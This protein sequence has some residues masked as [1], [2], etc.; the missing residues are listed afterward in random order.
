M[1]IVTKGSIGA[2]VAAVLISAAMVPVMASTTPKSAENVKAGVD[3]WSRGEYKKAVEA[4]RPAAIAGDPDAQFNLGQAYKLGRGVP[5]D[6]ALAEEWYRK[7]ALQDHFQ[8][9]DAYGLTLFQNNKRAEAVPWL[10][11]SAKRGEP[12]AQLVLG[13]MLFNGDSIT[14]DWVR[15]YALLSR[16][17]AA[18]LPQ[19]AKTLAQMDQYIPADTRQQ[20][21]AL[22]R[23]YEAMAERPADLPEVA[24]AGSTGVR[25][26]ELPPSTAS[27][28]G[29]LRPALK[30]VS[31]P[32][33]KGSSAVTARPVKPMVAPPPATVVPKVAAI[34]PVVGAGW[35]VQVG[36]FKEEANA[37]GLW[38]G[39]QGKI[40]TLAALQ[41]F[42]VRSGLITRLQAG[43]LASKA[44]A[45][46]V[47]GEIRVKAAGTPCVIVAP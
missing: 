38:R 33:G 6:L 24:G 30:P 45:E 29:D 25:S 28:E 44:E 7:A 22:A 40:S 32:G 47:C 10:E 39:L 9:Q 19:G 23:E 13:T 26:A 27:G 15:A 43:S 11:R 46:R 12:R 41:P 16:S 42:Y 3:A 18:G 34:K 14:K 4:W 31:P 21:I 2:I 1:R 35:R 8:A 20:G 36:A 5:V 17:A 37:R